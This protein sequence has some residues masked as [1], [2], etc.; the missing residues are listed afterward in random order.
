VL[1]KLLK[2]KLAIALREL[3]INH[4]IVDLIVIACQILQDV[5]HPKPFLEIN[6]K[7]AMVAPLGLIGYDI[8]LEKTFD[9]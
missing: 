1:T 6:I 5:A 3:A 4:S 2:V 9:L 8:V 7:F